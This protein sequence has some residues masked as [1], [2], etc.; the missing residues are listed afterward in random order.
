MLISAH[1]RASAAESGRGA[2][3]HARCR[4][5]DYRGIADLCGHLCDRR[6]RDQGRRG[7]LLDA[8]ASGDRHGATAGRFARCRSPA[9]RRRQSAARQA[10][11]RGATTACDWPRLARWRTWAIGERARDV[12]RPARLAELPHPEPEPSGAAGSDRPDRSTSPRKAKPEDRAKAVAAW[13]QWI[14]TNGATAKLTLPLTEQ[15]VPLGRTLLRLAERSRCWSSS[16]PTT[17][18]GGK[19]SCPVPAWGCQGLPNGHRLV[20]VYSQ[21][22]VI[23]YDD[24]GKEIWRKD[25]LPG[26]P[27]SV[28][29]LDNGNTLVACADVQQVIEIAPDGTT[30]TDHRARPADVG[31]AAGERQ[32]ARRPAAGEPR[33]RGR[34]GPARSSGRPAPTIGPAMPSGWK[35][36]TR[37]SA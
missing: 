26:P 16:M 8:L 23:E 29:R 4:S 33:R 14:A 31:P 10:A 17:R 18:S 13:K 28:Q 15:H 21:S 35:T 37:S 9:A 25:G 7:A 3:G 11:E 24:D 32:H 36:A 12:R 1:E 2:A 30:T 5:A 20:A 19:R 34:S 22:M 6:D 27:Y